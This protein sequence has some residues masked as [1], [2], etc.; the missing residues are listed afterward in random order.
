MLH[1]P[2]SPLTGWFDTIV[3]CRSGLCVMPT[4]RTRVCRT[5]FYSH[6]LSLVGEL[7]LC[8][9]GCMSTL[10]VEVRAKRMFWLP[11]TVVVHGFTGQ[12]HNPE[13]YPTPRAVG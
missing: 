4:P 5:R 13:K 8:P 7:S 9:R 12:K 11:G 1:M 6:C 10:T 3:A 2:G